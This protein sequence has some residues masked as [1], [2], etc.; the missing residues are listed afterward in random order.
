MISAYD[1][2]HMGR[3]ADHCFPFAKIVQVVWSCFPCI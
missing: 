1:L 3:L 2:E